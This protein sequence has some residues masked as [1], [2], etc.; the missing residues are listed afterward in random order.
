MYKIKTIY[1]RFENKKVSKFWL[2]LWLIRKKFVFWL[3][4]VPIIVLI[5]FYY[6]TKKSL[7]LH[8]PK[9]IPFW[10]K[11]ITEEDEMWS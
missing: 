10:L 3:I 9:K 11:N 4:I 1:P 7:V 6:N 5:T 8:N 2:E